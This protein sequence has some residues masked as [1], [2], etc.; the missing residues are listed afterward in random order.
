MLPFPLRSIVRMQAR[1]R[2]KKGKL[3]W[4]ARVEAATPA[5]R[6]R[7]LDF[8]RVVALLMVVVGHW[9]VRVVL[10]G[11]DGRP[12]AAYLLAIAPEWQA[13]TLLWQVMPLFFV[14]GGVVN[15]GSWRRAR[16]TGSAPEAWVATRVRRLLRPTLPLLAVL[17]PAAALLPAEA[18]VFDLGVAIL[19]LWFLAAYVAVTALTPSALAQHEAGRSAWLLAAGGTAVLALDLLRFLWGG[20]LI[21]GQPAVAAPNF[22]LVWLL[23]H[24]LGFYAADDRLP[25]RPVAL[26][27]VAALALG[28]LI[29][30]R[31]PLGMIP[32]E[33]TSLPNNG[34]PPSVALVALGLVQGGVALALRGPV[35]ASLHR[36]AL[37]APVAAVGALLMPIYLWHQPAMVA[38]ANLA[39]PA[40]WLPLSEVPDAQWWLRRPLWV[41]LC[42]LAL[43]PLVLLAAWIERA[44]PAPRAAAPGRLWL[45]LGVVLVAAGI[46]GLIATRLVQPAMPLGL[47]LAPLAAFL[48]GL[49]ALGVLHR[50]G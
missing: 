22:L 21:A 27:A 44:V 11:A 39:Y 3:P 19:P 31:W 34:S 12:E 38:V 25:R 8:L 9:V 10:E 46:A 6:D 28:L 45:V 43:V 5:E 4:A 24:Q 7:Y 14:V 37:W 40:G 41:A 50:R 13:A 2:E 33:G 42:A 47:P 23:L 30:G 16:A 26:A 20:P 1:P 17:V 15:A 49:A 35:T 29:A 48:A 36:P 32:I 18:L